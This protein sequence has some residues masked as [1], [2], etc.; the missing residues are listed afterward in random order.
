[1]EVVAS[2]V[3]RRK[4]CEEG[5]THQRG[6]VCNSRLELGE[7]IETLTREVLREAEKEA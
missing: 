4:C 7:W 2:R 3:A 6:E 5:Q 1:M